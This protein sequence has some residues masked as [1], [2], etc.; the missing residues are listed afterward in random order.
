MIPI[1]TISCAIRLPLY[2]Y[3]F[4]TILQLLFNYFI[5]NFSLHYNS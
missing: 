2:K 3:Y 5:I 4:S 1:N